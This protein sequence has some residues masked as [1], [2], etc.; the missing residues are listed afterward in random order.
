MVNKSDVFSSPSESKILSLAGL[1]VVYK[2]LS[3]DTNGAVSVVEHPIDAGV[4]V[5]P[6]THTREDEISCVV[7]GEIGVK[8]GDQEFL[9]VPGTWIF[10]PRNVQHTFWNAGPKRAKLIEIITPGAFAHYFEELVAVLKESGSGPPNLEKIDELSRKYGI[11]YNMESVPAL[12]KK[13]N[14]HLG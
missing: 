6:H 2:V 3:E 7:E 9:A 13:Y 12:E 10:K 4:L 11:S 14:V 1:G 8:I 5:R